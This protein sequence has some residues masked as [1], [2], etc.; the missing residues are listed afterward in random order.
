MAAKQ[1]VAVAIADAGREGEIRSIGEIDAAPCS[2]TRLMGKVATTDER[3][4]FCC[5]AEPTGYGLHHLIT[6]LG[7][8]RTVVAPSLIP[9][10]PSESVRTGYRTRR[11]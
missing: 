4:H 2:M 9:R 7:H 5:E 6:E 11:C 10:K 8:D 1:R 3:L